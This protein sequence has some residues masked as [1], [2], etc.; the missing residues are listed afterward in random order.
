MPTYNPITDNVGAPWPLLAQDRSKC[1]YHEIADGMY[2]ALTYEGITDIYRN[3]QVWSSKLGV[4]VAGEKQEGQQILS[5]A[6]PPEHTRQRRLFVKSLS[7]ARMDAMVPRIQQVMDD[8]I[9]RIDADGGT[10]DL[11]KKVADILPA[12]LIHDLLG[13]QE[14]SRSG[15]QRWTEI[16]FAAATAF[17][18]EPFKRDIEEYLEFLTN[19]V[20]ERKADPEEHDDL[21]SLLVSA[22][23]DK[24]VLLETEVVSILKFLL[25]AGA[26]TTKGAVTNAIFALETHPEEKARYLAD[27]DGLVDTFV[28]EGLR[29]DG[30]VKGLLRTAKADTALG[31]I[32]ATEG[33][34]VFM[35]FAAGNHDP[36]VYDNPDVFSLERD[37]GETVP[38]LSFGTGVHHCLGM[39]L[40]R[41]ELRVMLATL[42]KRLPN[43]RLVD[44]FTPQPIPVLMWRQWDSM[45]M[46]YDGPV[47]PRLSPAH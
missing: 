5:F 42:Y 43:L 11:F 37:Y 45:E 26:D 3:H 19:L 29:F 36:A 28:E 47:G 41:H 24:E 17:D 15:L 14:E 32:P 31:D 7:P 8:I 12:Q 38:H 20:R 35:C 22:E 39:N 27:I 25:S 16:E 40:A 1:P 34:Q 6:D 4:D 23:I 21:I 2:E 44:G 10:F 9:D 46:V 30:P 18:Q 33:T 13:I